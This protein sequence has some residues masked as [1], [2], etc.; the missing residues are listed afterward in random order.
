MPGYNI[1]QC[2]ILIYCISFTLYYFHRFFIFVAFSII[3]CNDN[4]CW[5]SDAECKKI[6]HNCK[7]NANI[8]PLNAL[9][10]YLNSNLILKARVFE[11]WIFHFLTLQKSILFDS[12]S[13]Q[14]IE[15][16]IFW[17]P[18]LFAGLNI[19]QCGFVHR[20]NRTLINYSKRNTS[21]PSQ[22]PKAKCKTGT[23]RDMW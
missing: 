17:R 12:D 11:N 16:N 18:N 13:R 5:I 19:F 20:K 7:C 21:F 10:I 15:A 6:Y 1:T 4:F 3:V 2:K 14:S 23:S 22:H 8:F 9:T